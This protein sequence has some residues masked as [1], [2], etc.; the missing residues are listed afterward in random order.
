MSETHAIDI[1]RTN[2]SAATGV[3]RS[4]RWLFID[5]AAAFG[6]HEAMLLRWLEE[7]DAQRAA[8]CFVLARQA[9]K[10]AS[11]AARH[12][13]VI[14][15]PPERRG[16]L[17]KLLGHFRDGV[18]LTRAIFEVKPTLCVVAEGCLLDQPLFALL[19]RLLRRRVVIY[20][21]M[22][23]TSASMGFG[24]ARIRDALVRRWYANL[25]HAW[26]TITREQATEFR[27]WAR[28]RRPIFVLP[29]TVSRS[30][31][32]EQLASRVDGASGAT[33]RLRILVLGRIEAHQKGLD[34]LLD[35]LS[36]HAQLAEQITVSFVGTGP[37]ESQLRDRL[38]TNAALA[39]W[40]SLQPWSP[41]LLAMRSH[42]VLLM[43]SRYEGVP[44]VML[45]AMAVGL[46]VVAPDLPGTRAFL[47]AEALFPREDMPAA[48]ARL[49]RMFD[50][51]ARA[52]TVE[53][54]R[55]TFEALASNAAFSAAVQSLS[56]QF[57]GLARTPARP[58]S[59]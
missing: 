26:L 31:E 22:V 5:G 19:A 33:A 30:L 4:E 53:R 44:L 58:R 38:A 12:A 57:Q 18:A 24:S 20:V 17:N 59:A 32:A 41:T 39:S 40:I 15:L 46:P 56:Q 34:T 55:S 13:R 51:A 9:S 29:N 21:P 47:G 36:A 45:E 14:E 8:Q 35:Y 1:G 52:R 49:T 16:A 42:D 28:V 10:L 2:E 50:P 54:N 11:D 48:M 27:A 3:S 23:Q 43:T 7:L 37:F 6:G 25:P